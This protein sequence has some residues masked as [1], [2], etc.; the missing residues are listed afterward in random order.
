MQQLLSLIRLADMYDSSL[1]EPMHC[2]LPGVILPVGKATLL[3]AAGLSGTRV[4]VMVAAE[5]PIGAGAGAG[6]GTARSRCP[7]AL[8]AYLACSGS[9]GNGETPGRGAG[10][11]TENIGSLLAVASLMKLPEP[12]CS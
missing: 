5:M 10:T 6:A 11:A 3:K 2:S 8:L 1:T 12:S 7:G 4:G 9:T